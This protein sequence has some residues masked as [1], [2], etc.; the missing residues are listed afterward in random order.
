MTEYQKYETLWAKFCSLADN[1][2][3]ILWWYGSFYDCPLDKKREYI[4]LGKE[5]E[6]VQQEINKLFEINGGRIWS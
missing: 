4:R 1:C 2:A 6:L 3:A 5:Q